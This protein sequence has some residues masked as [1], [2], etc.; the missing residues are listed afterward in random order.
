MNPLVISVGALL[1]V[2][3]IAA[4]AWSFAGDKKPNDVVVAPGIS[5]KVRTFQTRVSIILTVS[6][7]ILLAGFVIS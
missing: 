5:M 1:T 3:S 7:L 6:L 4:M 2:F